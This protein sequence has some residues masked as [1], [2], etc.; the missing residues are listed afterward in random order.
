MRRPARRGAARHSAGPCGRRGPAGQHVGTERRVGSSAPGAAAAGPQLLPRG[1]PLLR[2]APGAGGR[3]DPGAEEHPGGRQ[4]LHQVRRGRA[5]P[6][7]AL[8]RGG[9][10]TGVRAAEGAGR[11]G[12]GL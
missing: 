1:E 8:S 7:A 11:P 2:R 6:E 4:P 9:Y 5:R 3:G 10:V 12:R